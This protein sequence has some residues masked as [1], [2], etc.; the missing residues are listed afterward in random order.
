MSKRPMDTRS[1][2][3]PLHQLPKRKKTSISAPSGQNS[4]STL[5]SPTASLDSTVTS[6][7]PRPQLMQAPS[8]SMSQGNP[9]SSDGWTKV[10]KRKEKKAKKA[11][12]S[13]SN[14]PPSFA[15]NVQEL[16][17][18][19]T[20]SLPEIRDLA[21]HLMGDASPPSWLRVSNKG[22]I[23]RTVVLLVPGITRQIFVPHL[24]PK[25]NT[26]N[27]LLHVPPFSQTSA[28]SCK[29]SFLSTFLHAVPTKAPGEAQRMHSV[30]HGFFMGPVSGEE[31][32]RR[33][34]DRIKGEREAAQDVESFLLTPQQLLENEYPVPS[35]MSEASQLDD[36]WLQIPEYTGTGKDRILAL[37]CEMCI[38]TAGR[39]L[40]HVC[41][42]DFETGEKLY[43]ELVLPSA[44]ITDYLTRFS[45][46]TPSSLESVN[47][48]LADVQEHLRSLMSPSTILL[49]HSLES[50]LK[51]MKVAHGRCIDTSVIYHHPR[52]HPLK[53]GL[54]WLMKKWAGKDIQ[55]RGDGGHDPEEDARSCIELLKLKLKN[56]AGFGHFMVDMENILERMARSNSKNG[57]MIRTAVIDYGNPS[58]WLGSKATSTTACTNDDD[59][60]KG[61]QDSLGTH[62]FIF[63]R[64]LEVSE[65][66]GWT[67]KKTLQMAG[68]PPITS[69]NLDQVVPQEPTKSAD[70]LYSELDARLTALYRSLPPATAFILFTGH[71]DPRK[72]AQMNS[73]KAAFETAIRE[74][75]TPEQIPKEEW[76]TSQESRELEDEVERVKQG[77]L[78]LGMK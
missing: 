68:T 54:K 31:K 70:E 47:T 1:S 15:F 5:H 78:F 55:N 4:I 27:P 62:Q 46:I 51:A 40:T 2:P 6:G 66:L 71:D 28:P 13:A 58:T 32:K 39:E 69:T 10:N 24:Q 3:P 38:T 25:P 41:I 36:T 67:S 20:I 63:G 34:L 76:W 45:G 42:I 22:S 30:L 19:Q 8:S 74:G 14:N 77:L 56:G 12:H 60:V 49:G 18:L 52:G 23:Q 35:W 21:L 53:P 11:M 33:I 59:V 44:P 61:I 64:M 9:Q 37:D 50:D 17:R 29:V 43:D 48:R 72:M 26:S 16:V 75:K 65:G 57:K 7:P 73:K